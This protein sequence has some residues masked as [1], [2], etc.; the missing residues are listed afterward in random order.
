MNL[1]KLVLFWFV[2]NIQNRENKYKVGEKARK[3][4]VCGSQW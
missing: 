4:C 2:V 3:G 1:N